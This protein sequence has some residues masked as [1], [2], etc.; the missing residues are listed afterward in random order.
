MRRLTARR[1]RRPVSACRSQSSRRAAS[2]SSSSSTPSPGPS[3]SSSRPA[4]EPRAGA[5]RRRE[6]AR[7]GEP[8]GEARLGQGAAE[9]PAPRAR[10]R[11]SRPAPRARSRGTRGAPAAISSAAAIPP[12]LASFTVASSQAPSSTASRASRALVTLSSAASGIR[13][14]ERSSAIASSPPTGCSASSIVWRAIARSRSLASLDVSTRRWRRPG[15]APRR[16]AP[17]EP[18]PTW[19]TSPGSPT[20]SLKVLK[21]SAAHSSRQR[22]RPARVGRRQ[23]RV[24]AHR[25]GPLGPEQPPDW[26]SG[27]L[28]GEV[29]EGDVDRRQRL[30]RHPSVAAAGERRPEPLRVDWPLLERRPAELRQLPGDLL[31]VGPAAEGQ[32]RGLAEALEA[33]GA[34]PEQDQAPLGELAARGDVGLA[35]GER[36]GDRLQRLQPHADDSRRGVTAAISRP[37]ETVRL[38]AASRAPVLASAWF[39]EGPSTRVSTGRAAGTTSGSERNPSAAHQGPSFGEQ[40]YQQG[41]VG[42]ADQGEVEAP[43]RVAPEADG[44][45]PLAGAAVGVDVADVVDDEDRRGEAADRDREAEGE[46]VEL[47]ELDV[48]GA[49]DRDQAEEEEDE[50]LAEPGVAVGPR[51]A[52]VEDAGEDRGDADREDHRARRR[53]PGRCRRRPRPRRRPRSRPGRSAAPPGRRR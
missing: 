33:V 9:A 45:G 24:A 41:Q 43:G 46:P 49:V 16:R 29:V 51:A 3:P 35:E 52:R 5:D 11:R 13:V 12:T 23:G 42:D 44:E 10:R 22:P 36:V 28:R 26:Y 17:R 6:E 15:S 32:G 7:G 50:E 4:F 2:A 19:V 14:R 48:V 30:R 25:L 8:V 21:P 53:W 20:L 40:R 39:S 27:R 38:K 1:C 31:E 37:A 47:L 34:D 18:S